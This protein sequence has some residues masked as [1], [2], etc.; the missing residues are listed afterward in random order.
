VDH[1]SE[2]MVLVLVAKPLFEHAQV[3]MDAQGTL[4]RGPRGGQILPSV[5]WEEAGTELSETAECDP[6]SVQS[7]HR[8]M[9]G[10]ALRC[11]QQYLP[12]RF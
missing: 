7:P 3:V 4:E 8:G 10:G 2:V 12:C 6:K 9:A 5:R 11:R 1:F